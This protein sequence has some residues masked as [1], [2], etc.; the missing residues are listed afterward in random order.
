MSRARRRRADARRMPDGRRAAGALAALRMRL[1]VARRSRCRAPT[2]NRPRSRRS[3]TS[4]G[5]AKAFVD[6]QNDVTTKDVELADRE[7]FSAVEHLKRYTTL[8]MATDQGKTSNV[9]GLAIMAERTGRTIPQ[10][11]TTSFR[12]PYVPVALRRDRRASSRQGIPADPAHAVACLGAGAGRGVRRER[13]VAARAV[14]SA[15]AARRIGSRPSTARCAP[16]ARPSACAM[17]RRSARSTFEGPDAAAFLD[18]VYINT[19]STLP[20]GKVRYGLML[21]EDGFVIDDGTTV[22][23]GARALR[24]DHHDRQRR[25]A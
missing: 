2:T 13:A 14:L 4:G 19:L 10:V 18:R 3:G 21:R 12:P 11:G 20:V 8:G 23:A 6:F 25:R 17:S 22:A 15:R 5:R 7:G 9:T 24:H 16:C 1:S